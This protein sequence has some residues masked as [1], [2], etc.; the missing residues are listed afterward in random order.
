MIERLFSLHPSAND[1]FDRLVKETGETAGTGLG[2]VSGLGRPAGT[3]PFVT[4]ADD[5]T[6]AVIFQAADTKKVLELIEKL[7]Q[8]G[9]DESPKP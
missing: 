4:A 1:S 2:P 5:R 9:A 3:Q 6:N 7:D 8:P